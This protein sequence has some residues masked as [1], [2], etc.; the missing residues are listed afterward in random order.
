APL[1]LAARLARPLVARRFARRRRDPEPSPHPNDGVGAS[2]VAALGDSPAAGV[3]R[4]ALDGA[5]DSPVLP[6]HTTLLILAGSARARDAG[7]MERGAT[8]ALMV[9]GMSPAEVQGTLGHLA[10]P[11]VDARDTALLAFA[12]ETVRCTPA[13]IQDQLRG[14]TAAFAL[15]VEQR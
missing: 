6:P 13:A 10:S 9:V 11:S 5:R 14:L 8:A 1:L 3:L 4:R 15:D 12:R 2:V 7:P